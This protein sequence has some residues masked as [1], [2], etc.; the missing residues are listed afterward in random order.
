MFLGKKKAETHLCDRGNGIIG[1]VVDLLAEAG[2]HGEK[3][4]L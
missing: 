3:S 4:S 2:E 1:H